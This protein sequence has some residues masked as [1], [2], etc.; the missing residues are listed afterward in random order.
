M[1][2]KKGH[3]P[4]M[5]CQC[6]TM[7]WSWLFRGALYWVCGKEENRGGELAKGDETLVFLPRQWW[8]CSGG[9]VSA[10][11]RSTVGANV[12]E[13][14]TP[15]LQR[16][17]PPFAWHIWLPDDCQT[18]AWRRR[19]WAAGWRQETARFLGLVW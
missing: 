10:G 4:P 16:Q 9:V 19:T 6:H 1:G 12:A 5:Y 3:C 11:K 13:G 2:E 14:S 18:L 15:R 8:W 17:S 7:M